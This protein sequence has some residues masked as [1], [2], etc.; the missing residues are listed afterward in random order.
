[1]VRQNGV[2][3][4]LIIVLMHGAVSDSETNDGVTWFMPLSD[5]NVG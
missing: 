5:E 3:T 4:A 1:M 2:T